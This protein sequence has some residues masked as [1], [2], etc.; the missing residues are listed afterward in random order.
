MFGF[1]LA[2]NLRKMR[3]KTRLNRDIEPQEVF[4]DNLAKKKEAQLGVSEKMIE[5]PL[6]RKVL[7]GLLFF[8]IAL[9]LVLLAKTFQFQVLENKK[10]T[11]L[12]NENKFL[13]HSIKAARGVIYDSRGNQLVFNKSSFDLILNKQK[14]PSSDY[15]KIEVLKKVSEIIKENFKDLE[16]RIN[17]AKDQNIIILENLD[18]QTLILLETKITQLSGFKIEQNDIREYK[19]GPSFAHLIGYTGKISKEELK[20]NPEVYSGFDYIGR[21]GIEKS[22]EEALRKNPG[23]TQIERDAYGNFLS[24]EIIS[25]PESGNSLVLWLDSELQKKIE[26]MLHKILENVEAEKAV[27][28]ALD[29]KTGGI[30]ALVSIPSY[31]NNL[32][33]E[34]ADQEALFNLLADPREPL[35]NLAISGL[36]PTGSVIKPFVASAALEEEIISPSKKINC[37]GGIA[38]SHRY[39]PGITTVKQDWR[40][41]YATNMRKAIAE[42]CNVYFYTIGGG[43]ENQEG[44]GPSRIKEYLELFGWGNKTGIDLPGEVEGLIPSVEWKKEVKKEPWWDGDTYN[45]SIGQGDISVTPLQ[46]AAAFVAIANKGTLY[47]PKGVKQIIDKEKNLIEEISPE[48]LRENFIDPENLQIV[49]EGMRR[50]V[51][52]EDSPYASAVSLNSLPIKAAAKTG[53]AQTSRPDYYHNWITVFAPYDDPQIVLVIMIENVKGIRVATLPVA[54]E[55]LNWYFTR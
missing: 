7:K 21:E 47:K 32:F 55:V 40:I 35:F 19:D 37:E 36:Y 52:G 53:T 49:R 9:A 29:P 8:I 43:Y 41:H 6:S 14:L 10:F 30:L 25:L 27:G 26:E 15:E 39:E 28:V 48:I 33:S 54:K 17:E 13:I 11:A 38:I 22:Y 42:S 18:H 3:V 2:K 24:K 31:D 34:G 4:L 16:K 23:K 5:V 12:A 50:A 44:L 51:T 46:V 45:L 20:E 1:H